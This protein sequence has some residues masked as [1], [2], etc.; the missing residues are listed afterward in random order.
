MNSEKRIWR[1]FGRAQNMPKTDHDEYQEDLYN[2]W[3]SQLFCGDFVNRCDMSQ[4]FRDLGSDC[5]EGSLWYW[6]RSTW[7]IETPRHIFWASNREHTGVWDR[8]F[9]KMVADV[10][11]IKIVLVFFDQVPPLKKLLYVFR[12]IAYLSI[13]MIRFAKRHLIFL[14]SAKEKR[15]VFRSQQLGS[16]SRLLLEVLDMKQKKSK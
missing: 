14:F 13:Y 2:H 5:V 6:F 10:T 16:Q 9:Q 11:P 3:S 15:S 4:Q 1:G 8:T 12:S 7:S